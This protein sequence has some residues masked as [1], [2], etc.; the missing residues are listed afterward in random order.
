[1][2]PIFLPEK[3]VTGRFACEVDKYA[4]LLLLSIV[5]SDFEINFESNLNLSPC[6]ATKSRMQSAIRLS[7][8]SVFV[9][10]LGNE[11]Y[12]KFLDLAE[13]M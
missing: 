5:S 9:I 10:V 12:G 7:Q 6:I 1:M 11:S 4:L 13:K 2:L 3:R 8:L